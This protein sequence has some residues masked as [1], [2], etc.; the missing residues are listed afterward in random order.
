[1][2]ATNNVGEGPSS[3][4][5]DMV[6]VAPSVPSPPYGLALQAGDRFVQLNW[7]QPLDDGH[8]QIIGYRIYRGTEPGN[9][10]LLTS[11]GTAISFLDANL[12]NDHIYYYRL[13]A[14][15]TIGQGMGT[16]VMSA[17]PKAMPVENP[18]LP[19]NDDPDSTTGGW[20][21]N[22]T[23]VT[24]AVLALTLVGVFIYMRNPQSGTT[25]PP[26]SEPEHPDQGVDD[27]PDRD[28]TNEEG[29]HD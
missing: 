4:S 28:A 14:V 1:V 10:T 24:V 17:T 18:N 2:T 22:S 3:E 21:L 9:L 12:V 15:N 27:Y 13:T 5:V 16:E 20:S 8:S 25:S 23:L 11:L 26:P 29:K 19:M 7:S 6:P